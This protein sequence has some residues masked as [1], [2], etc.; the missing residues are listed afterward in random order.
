MKYVLLAD[1]AVSTNFDT[2]EF[3][4]NTRASKTVFIANGQIG[5]FKGTN[6]LSI[7]NGATVNETELKD[8]TDKYFKNNKVAF[9]RINSIVNPSTY[10]TIF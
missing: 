7:D 1:S 4:L 5:I 2:K 3:K 9:N 10:K 8:F 6:L